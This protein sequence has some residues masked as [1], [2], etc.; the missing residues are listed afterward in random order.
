MPSSR[1]L[2][3]ARRGG[4]RSVGSWYTMG[5]HAIPTRRHRYGQSP[6]SLPP[7]R[8]ERAMSSRVRQGNVR[9]S[10]G[11]V[12]RRAQG[13]RGE[14]QLMST[15]TFW[16]RGRLAVLAACLLA[17]MG[18]VLTS[19]EPSGA[20][21]SPSDPPA[22]ETLKP[23]DYDP[24]PEESERKIAFYEKMYRWSQEPTANQLGLDAVSY[25]LDLTVDPSINEVSGVLVGTFEVDAAT[26]DV[27]DLDL[28]TTLGVSA[29]TAGGVP[30]TFTHI[31]DLLSIDLDRTYLQDETVTVEVTYAGPPDLSYGAF[32]WNQHG[33]E[34]MIWT[35]S[36]PFGARS[37]WPCDDWSDDKADWMDIRVTVPSG[38]IVASNGTLV[39]VN[40]GQDWDT[41]WWHEEYPIATYLVSLAIH[42]YAVWSDYYQYDETD[43]MEIKFFIYPDH[44]DETY[45]ANLQVKD[46]IAFFATVYGEYPFINEKYG[47]AEFPWGGAMEH[48]TCTSTGAFYETIIAHEL[49][50]QWWGDMVTC[51]DFH[52]IWLNEGFAVYSEALWLEHAYGPDGY[53]GKMNSTKYFGGGTIYVPDLSDWGRIFHTGLT[54]YKA[55]WVVHMLRHVIGDANFWQLL[56]DYREAYEFGAATTEDLQALAEGISGMDLTDFF[57]QWIYGEYYPH[58]GYTWEN[59]ETDRGWELHLTIDQIQD[60]CG[61]FHMPIDIHATCGGGVVEEFVVD[62]SLAHEEYVLPLDVPAEVVELD[63]NDWILKR[64]TEPVIDPTFDAGILLVNGVDWDTYGTEI[65]NAYMNNAFWGDLEIS[66]WDCFD[67]PDGGYPET[68]PPCEGHGRVPSP[69]LGSYETVIWVGND[70]NGD[71]GC[72]MNTSILSYLEAGGNVLLMTRQGSNFLDDEMCDYLGI[73]FING[74]SIY[75]C[76][77]VHDELTDIARTGTQS[78]CRVFDQQLTQPTSTLLYIATLGYDPDA[79]IGVWRAPEGGG[80][81]NPDGAQFAFLSGRPYRWD[82]SDL[83]TN[84]ETIVGTLFAG[85][86]DVAE[87]A[88]PATRLRLRAQSPALR[89]ARIAFALPHATRARLTVLDAQ[90]RLV[91]TLFEG[92]LASGPHDLQWDGRSDAGAA[93]AAGVYFARLEAGARQAVRPLLMVR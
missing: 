50:H 29:C 2:H 32:G 24:A 83:R 5:A 67:E 8:R 89:G 52:H 66:F 33:G 3:H 36:E 25:E 85:A 42:P 7:A 73:N 26:A 71:L 87:E 18:L 54:Y 56:H 38:L 49:A 60:N 59:V 19:G 55:S 27:V 81:Y 93:V 17:I 77:S 53:W 1:H 30:T 64:I 20:E 86:S 91:R 41:Y 48:Q 28:A 92:S 57:Q 65:W 35:L 46:M 11:P 88:M 70:Y 79:G 16:N 47:H 69:T 61:V 82:H 14:E 40:Y 23:W 13:E 22:S 84:V 4:T 90:G 75:D 37:W 34:P 44:V 78:Y 68:L 76:V 51:A 72:W 74:N 10:P 63:P 15:R 58:Y 62:N 39:D 80:T 43:S 12:H 21:P 6:I 31:D 45:E 9:R